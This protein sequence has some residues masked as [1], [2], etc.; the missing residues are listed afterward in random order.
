MSEA[1]LEKL[2]FVML[3]AQ[4]SNKSMLK[5]T[6]YEFADKT[7]IRC[8]QCACAEYVSNLAPLGMLWQ[9]KSSAE[10]H[11]GSGKGDALLYLQTIRFAP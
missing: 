6:P 1:K 8:L 10:Y 7:L 9:H 5:L 2:M 4:A 3:A 11:S